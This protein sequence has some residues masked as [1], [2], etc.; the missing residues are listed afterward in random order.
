ML[1]KPTRKITIMNEL[2]IENQWIY[3]SAS[4]Y[5]HTPDIS[6]LLVTTM[7]LKTVLS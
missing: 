4:Q 5:K 6:Q 3:T 7:K 2:K 1:T